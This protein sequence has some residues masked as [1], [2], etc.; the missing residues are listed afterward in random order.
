MRA[1]RERG[2][3]DGD[4]GLRFE[5]GEA[6]AGLESLF[7][8]VELADPDR[9]A[10]LHLPPAEEAAYPFALAWHGARVASQA[11][12]LAERGGGEGA[13]RL[14]TAETAFLR[15]LDPA[16]DAF[17]DRLLKNKGPRVR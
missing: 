5:A 4:A 13:S 9:R 6:F 11:V 14:R 17:R 8:L 12:H 1:L 3:W 15:F 7:A 10:A 2:A 16:R